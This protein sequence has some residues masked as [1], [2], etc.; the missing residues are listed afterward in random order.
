MK[1]SLTTQA[2]S[3][4]SVDLQALVSVYSSNTK[5]L[6]SFYGRDHVS[7]FFV[8]LTASSTVLYKLQALNEHL[9]SDSELENS[10]RFMPREFKDTVDPGE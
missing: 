8:P 3:N 1:C 7:Y 2:H 10:G 4:S 5:L 6:V 9:K